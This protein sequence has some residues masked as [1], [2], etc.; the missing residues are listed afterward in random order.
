MHRLLTAR[1]AGV[2]DDLSLT[3]EMVESSSRETRSSSDFQTDLVFDRSVT[4][5]ERRQ[6]LWNPR[7]HTYKRVSRPVAF[8]DFFP[9][10]Y[11]KM[12]ILR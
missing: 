1:R 11:R 5:S 12:K 3:L 2:L 8:S 6:T 9:I 4:F 7:Q 10:L